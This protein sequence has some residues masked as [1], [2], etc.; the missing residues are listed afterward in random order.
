MKTLPNGIIIIK[1][2]IL[3]RISDTE[4]IAALL[5]AYK[6]L[7]R[8]TISVT[9]E[10]IELGEVKLH[11]WS[12]LLAQQDKIFDEK[13]KPLL[14]KHLDYQILYFGLAPIPLAIHLGYRVGSMEKA[15][16]F[17]RHHEGDKSWQWRNINSGQ[18]Q[19]SGIPQEVHKSDGDIVIRVGTRFLIQKKETDE[20][21]LDPDREIEI[22]PP[23]LGQDIFGSS[24]QLAEYAAAFGEALDRTKDRLPETQGIHLFAAVPVGLAFL[25]GQEINPNAHHKVHVYEYVSG[26]STSYQHAFIVNEERDAQLV[27]ITDKEKQK[28]EKQRQ[29]FKLEEIDKIQKALFPELTESDEDHWFKA[30]PFSSTI[31][32]NPLDQI[33]WNHLIRLDQAGLKNTFLELDSAA[34]EGKNYRNAYYFDDVLLK[35][36]NRLLPKAEDVDTAFRLYCFKDSIHSASHGIRGRNVHTINQY[37][38]AVEEANYQ[39][40]VYALIHE[41]AY[42][43]YSIEDASIFFSRLI[44]ILLQT[45]WAFDQQRIKSNAMEVQRVNRYLVWYYQFI[46]IQSCTTLESIL[47]MLATK[48]IIELRLQSL[49]STEGK[50]MVFQLNRIKENELGICIL[51]QGKLNSFPNELGILSLTD[52][53]N[54]FR[55]HE[56]EKV[57]E[58][59]NALIDKIN[60]QNL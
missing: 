32:S 44:D 34:E 35:Q 49:R 9:P 10:Q 17:L 55:N 24:D 38:R 39:A 33:Y 42:Q 14:Q 27:E 4:V 53:I 58:V 8:H 28:F 40:D 36:L 30:L 5:P 23:E 54:G 12:S 20:I 7:P 16:A 52:L 22:Y 3:D 37:P 43:R 26:E 18:P 60:L 59:V 25:M 29:I 31:S 56:P 45:M 48:P 1:H 2:E 41:F 57:K 15:I 46:R 50:K 6:D 47:E 11:Y 19:I 21:I 51:N 13:V